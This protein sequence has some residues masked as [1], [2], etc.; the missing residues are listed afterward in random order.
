MD[1]FLSILEALNMEKMLFDLELKVQTYNKLSDDEKMNNMTQYD[2]IIQGRND[3]IKQISDYKV[4]L[5]NIAKNP[6]KPTMKHNEIIYDELTNL[7]ELVTY[8][9]NLCGLKHELENKKNNALNITY[10]EQ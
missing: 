6:E 8:Y 1:Q 9:K 4:M 5:H 7:E 2:T 10:I 3:L